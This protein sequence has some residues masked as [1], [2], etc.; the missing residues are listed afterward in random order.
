MQSRNIVVLVGASITAMMLLIF[1]ALAEQGARLLDLSSKW[2]IVSCI[3]LFVALFIAGYIRNFKGF[4]IELEGSL[5]SPISTTLN[6][7]VASALTTLDMAE[8][9]DVDYLRSLPRDKR[10]SIRVLSFEMRRK[11]YYTEGAVIE[12]FKYLP[13]IKYLIVKT[14][15]GEFITYI[16][17]EVFLNKIERHY[18]GLYSHERVHQFIKALEGGRIHDQYLFTAYQETVRSSMSLIDVMRLL[19]LEQLNAVPVMTESGRFLGL[20]FKET[21]EGKVA[22]IVLMT[23]ST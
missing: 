23:K 17:I 8:K 19:R 9:Q 14:K 18:D 2:I 22:D 16:P 12:Y 21:I 11:G 10:L 3:P 5:N 7:D 20:V 13:N 15:K 1:A 4:G 6:I